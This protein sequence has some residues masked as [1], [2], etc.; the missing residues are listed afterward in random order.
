MV[1]EF[2]AASGEPI[3]VNGCPSAAVIIVMDA[4]TR[5]CGVGEPILLG[6]KGDL[7]LG[8]IIRRIGFQT[9]RFHLRL[10]DEADDQG[11]DTGGE[12]CDPQSLPI[13]PCFVVGV[14]VAAAVD[15]PIDQHF[16]TVAQIVRKAT[17]PVILFEVI[18]EIVFQEGLVLVGKG[19]VAFVAAS[20]PALPC[21]A[22]AS[23]HPSHFPSPGSGF[24]NSLWRSCGWYPNH[25]P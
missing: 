22:P 17:V 14:I 21:S 13:W 8:H 10:E 19:G 11:D 25:R 1:L 18:Q 20:N 7:M 12:D 4:H 16:L 9:G 23:R 6:G 24:Y 15:L 3:A 5:L 2:S